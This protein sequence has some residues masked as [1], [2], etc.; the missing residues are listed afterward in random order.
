LHDIVGV[1]DDEVA[2]LQVAISQQPAEARSHALAVRL[3]DALLACV[4]VRDL[5]PQRPASLRRLAAPGCTRC[6]DGCGVPGC[7]GN[8]LEGLSLILPHTKTAR[9]RGVLRLEVPPGS[10]TAALLAE[11]LSWGR[12]ALL[13][14]AAGDALFLAPSGGPYSE[15][16]FNTR[17]TRSLQAYGLPARIT[18]CKVRLAVWVQRRRRRR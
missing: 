1:I 15:G 10:A 16:A 6:L 18:H 2:A 11:H 13:K 17:L 5:P 3:Q 9:S 4:A 12:A 14:G 7:R 8:R